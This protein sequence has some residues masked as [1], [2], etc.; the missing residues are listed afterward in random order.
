[1][2]A[3]DGRALCYH[4]RM[5]SVAIVLAAWA[6]AGC[7]AFVPKLQSPQLSIVNVELLSSNLWEQ[8]LRV[9]IRVENPND[10]VLP[11]AALSYSI[12]VAGQELGHGAANDSFVVPALGESEFAT[13]VSANMAGALLAILGRGH[14][15]ASDPIDYRIVGKITLGGGFV[16]SIPFEHQGTFKLQ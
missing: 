4:V 16:R 1:M 3:F 6:L 15:G 12:E 11:V 2:H 7:S 9:R 8:R 5:K 13:D 10:R 14:G